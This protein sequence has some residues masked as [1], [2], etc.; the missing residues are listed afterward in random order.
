MRA[1]ARVAYRMIDI[2]V[3]IIKSRP[4]V[5]IVFIS[6]IINSK[7]YS[8]SASSLYYN[9]KTAECW[10][11]EKKYCL[12]PVNDHAPC[13]HIIAEER[14]NIR[15]TVGTRNITSI[16]NPRPVKELKKKKTKKIN[17]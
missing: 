8:R 5:Q 17:F 15:G 3:V 4:S 13:I 11:T 14:D 9:A 6:G 7:A 2:N 10:I 1:R 16:R 12:N